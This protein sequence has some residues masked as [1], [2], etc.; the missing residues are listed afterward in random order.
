MW[1][2]FNETTCIGTWYHRIKC[3]SNIFSILNWFT[4]YFFI[5]YGRMSKLNYDIYFQVLQIH[6]CAQVA[7]HPQE[8]ESSSWPH[9]WV[10]S[11]GYHRILWQLF[12]AEIEPTRA[13]SGFASTV[14]ISGRAWPQTLRRSVLRYL[15]VFY[16]FIYFTL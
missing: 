14:I 6:S 15:F 10:K 7:S 5:W 4:N 3:T 12:F 2:L 11:P 8:W 1:F 13:N 16:L 9:V